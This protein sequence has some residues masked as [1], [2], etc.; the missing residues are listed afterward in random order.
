MRLPQSTSKAEQEVVA[1][2]VQAILGKGSSMLSWDLTRPVC[3]IP[4]MDRPTSR[5]QTQILAAWFGT[6]V[7][8]LAEHGE[9]WPRHGHRRRPGPVQ[10][11]VVEHEKMASKKE[12]DIGEEE[13]ERGGGGGGGGVGRSKPRS[14]SVLPRV[15]VVMRRSEGLGM[16]TETDAEAEAA[17]WVRAEGAVS[18]G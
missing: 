18:C 1:F 8:R 10:G 7:A 9:G 14:N 6:E 15:T 12:E 4:M 13:Q 2:T 16:P 3:C 17:W 11:R 5:T